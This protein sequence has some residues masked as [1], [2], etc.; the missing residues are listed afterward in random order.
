M[1]AAV[2][3]VSVPA[4]PELEISENG[5]LRHTG[6]IKPG[7]RSG[8]RINGHIDADGYKHFWIKGRSHKAHRL[9]C[10]AFHGPEPEGK[11]VVAHNDGNP[12]NNHYSNLR[13]TTQADNLADRIAHGTM[14]YGSRNGMAKLTDETVAKIAAFL[15]DG[16]THQET[17]D[18]F[19]TCRQNISKIAAGAAW[20]HMVK[21]SIPNQRKRAFCRNGHPRSLE[22][23]SRSGSCKDCAAARMRRIRAGLPPSPALSSRGS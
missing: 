20:P 11:P 15:R 6:P 2:K 9:V 23:V 4:D 16:H 13:W 22:R 8:Q 10:E 1:N 21:E 17:A 7:H 19:K 12:R 5:D 18:R 3:W 14:N